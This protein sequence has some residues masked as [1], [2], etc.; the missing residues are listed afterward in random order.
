MRVKDGVAVVTGGGSGIGA[1]CCRRLAAE[2]AS[3]AV[4][5][6]TGEAA[7]KIAAEIGGLALT[8][9]VANEQ[10]VGAAIRTVADKFGPINILVNNAGVAV[11]KPVHELAEED[12]TR[13]LDVNAKGAYLCSKHALRF[14]NESGGSIIHM[15]SVTGLTGVRNRGAYAAA[16]G[17]LIALAR[18]MAIE[19]APRRIRVNCVC[20]GFVRTPFIARLLATEE[21]AERLRLTHPLGRIGE[22]EDIANAVLFLASSESSWI[23]GQ[24]LAVDGGFT[25]GHT[26]DI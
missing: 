4:L 23:T 15:S 9:D 19:Y 12:W 5:D 25:A 6:C 13:V 10:A 16:K 20:P 14:W 22:P 21:S 26:E 8:A 17:A 1:A 24:C 2:G 18:T 11:R 7:E 3:V